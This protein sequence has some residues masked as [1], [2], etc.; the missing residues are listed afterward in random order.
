M[1]WGAQKCTGHLQ[2]TGTRSWGLPRKPVICRP[3]QTCLLCVAGILQC[4]TRTNDAVYRLMEVSAL[5]GILAL[6]P[7][8]IL[9]YSEDLSCELGQDKQA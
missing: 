3:Y 4:K 6:L 5:I 1:A 2:V 7:Q 8:A 9:S